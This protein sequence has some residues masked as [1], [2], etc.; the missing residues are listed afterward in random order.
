MADVVYTDVWASMGQEEEQE[1][2]AKVF[3]SYQ[4]NQQIM[5]HAKKEAIVMHC[6]PAHRGEEITSE[7]IDGPQ[8]VVLDQAENRLHVQKAILETLMKEDWNNG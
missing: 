3:K 1:E 8:S 5:G 6:L 2:R 7:V 4:I